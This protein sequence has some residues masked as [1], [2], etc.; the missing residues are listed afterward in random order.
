MSYQG[1]SVREVVD[2][3]NSNNNGWFLPPIQRQYVWGSRYESEKYI[4]KLFDSLL[5]R[6]PIGELIVWNNKNEMPYREFL[7][8]YH[9]DDISNE[10]EKGKWTRVDK[11]LVYDG[12]QRLQTL[13]S[14]LK[15]SINDR[16]LT[17]NLLF[18]TKKI[19]DDRD[20]VGFDFC[21]KNEELPPN[22]IR[23]NELFVKL[24]NE[25]TTYRKSIIAKLNNIK[26]LNEEEEKLIDDNIDLL[27]DIFVRKEIKTIAFYPVD[28]TD[29]TT[30]NEIFQRLNT[31]GIPLAQSEILWSRIKE[32]KHDFEEE[33][34]YFTREISQ[35]TNGYCIDSDQILQL[36]NLIIRGS[37][38]IAPKT[39]T[40]E[41]IKEFIKTW[42]SL[43]KAVYEFYTNF[44]YEIFK[45][46]NQAIIPRKLAIYPLIV[47]FKLLLDKSINFRKIDE[48]TLTSLKKYFI[49]SQINDW[50]L[51]SIVDNVSRKII[52]MNNTSEVPIFSFDDLKLIINKYRKLDLY[53][54]LFISYTWFSLKILTPNRLYNYTPD[55]RG[56]YNPEIDHIFPQGK[57]DSDNEY[58]QIVDIIWN[59][60]PVKGEV[61]N[62]KRRRDPLEFFQAND[63]KKYFT[64]YDYIPDLS[65]PDWTDYKE[66]IKNRRE[67]M[68]KFLKTAYNLEFSS[69]S[70]DGNNN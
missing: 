19:S 9:N 3:I 67:K 54:D 5:R 7:T 58:Q 51:Q 39:T 44:I 42:P 63:G 49:L 43:K 10:V 21:D 2:K 48:E 27:W 57:K 14:C 20:S 32:I 22:I 53:E 35:K 23:M 50:N 70:T 11:W 31:G 30:V 56:R 41:E 28:A 1:I 6:Y 61:N 37:T 17:Y 52:E 60:Q 40:P 24:D 8:D 26:E 66:F 47:F 65:S 64:D 36:L 15:Y 62:Y 33:V 68:I 45:I 16:V 46:N 12:Q 69:R 29:E 55:N 25:K 34:L 38:K 59:K 4:S 13:F 18:D